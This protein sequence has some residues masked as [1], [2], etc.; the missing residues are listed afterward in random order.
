MKKK[1]G[2]FHPSAGVYKNKL[3]QTKTWHPRRRSIV[4]PLCCGAWEAEERTGQSAR[5]QHRERSAILVHEIHTPNKLSL[6]KNSEKSSATR[7][8]PT[9]PLFLHKIPLRV[10]LVLLIQQRPP[11]L[12]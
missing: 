10:T 1:E 3:K 7:S 12:H 2:Y 6:E 5:R 8:S 9:P 4:I 11:F